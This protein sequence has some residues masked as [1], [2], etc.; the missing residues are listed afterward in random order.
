VIF[1]CSA[2]EHGGT[3]E[4]ASKLI[5]QREVLHITR[6]RT[7]RPGA[8]F[9][10]TTNSEQVRIEP[11]VM[12]SE[13]ERLPDLQ[14]YLKIASRPDWHQVKF[15]LRPTVPGRPSTVKCRLL[16]ANLRDDVSRLLRE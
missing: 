3:S 12:S 7:R 6:S 13:I 1:R 9:S 4:F 10:S 11:A 2:S 14:G 8:W 15:T 5:G 16:P